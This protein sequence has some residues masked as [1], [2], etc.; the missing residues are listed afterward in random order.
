[1]CI[2]IIIQLYIHGSSF[3]HV[4]GISALKLLPLQSACLK[5]SGCAEFGPL[6]TKE[7]YCFS[8]KCVFSETD[9]HTAL[10]PVPL[11]SACLKT[12]GCAEFGPLNIV[13]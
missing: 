7:K 6:N 10:K 9:H 5:T 2:G 12:S 1:M 11:Q 8:P 3:L 4:L 13:V